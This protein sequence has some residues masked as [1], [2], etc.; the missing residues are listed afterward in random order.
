M[1]KN[2]HEKIGCK[3]LSK[4]IKTCDEKSVKGRFKKG[5]IN[6]GRRKHN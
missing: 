3:E 4:Y 5:D 2:R 6:E 1:K